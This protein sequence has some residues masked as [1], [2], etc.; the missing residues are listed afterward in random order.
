MR[1]TALR[2]TAFQFTAVRF[3]AI[4]LLTALAIAGL[5]AGSVRAQQPDATTIAVAVAQGNAHC[6]IKTGTMKPEK[7]Q[8]IADGFLAQQKI[9]P[10]TST[11]VK[12]TAGFRD[13]MNAYIADQ[14][15][16]SALVEALQR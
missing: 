12:N 2:F 13:L 3:T 8:S 7:A 1:C 14:G 16:C 4:G 6:L 9:S 5:E 15:G 10:Q 11:A